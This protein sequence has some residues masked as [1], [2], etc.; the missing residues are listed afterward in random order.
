MSGPCRL[1][2]LDTSRNVPEAWPDGSGIRLGVRHMAHK[3]TNR[4]SASERDQQWAALART[5]GAIGLSATVLL[6]AAIFVYG[7]VG[8]PPLDAT[9]QAAAEY[10]RNS[11]PAWVQAAQATVSLALLAFLW[12]V[13]GLAL[14]LGRAEG[15][16]PW[17]STIVLASGVLFAAYGVLDA[18]SDAAAHRGDELGLDVAGYAYDVGTIGFANAWLAAASLAG[19]AGWVV[20]RTGIAARWTGWCA[21]ASGIGLVLARYFWFIESAWLVPYLLFWVWVAATSLRLVRHPR[22][23]SGVPRSE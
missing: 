17:R 19:F 15:Q 7:S 8:E 18:S 13:V 12:F 21:I 10:F 22:E 20:L 9:G 4:R 2:D 16:P 3:V 11:E 5:T 23:C 6:F 14:L 1:N